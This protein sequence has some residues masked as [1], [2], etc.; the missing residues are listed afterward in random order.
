MISCIAGWRANQSAEG[1]CKDQGDHST[2]DWCENMNIAFAFSLNISE[3]S[4]KHIFF[5]ATRR[6]QPAA[7]DA[8]KRAG[9]AQWHPQ[10]G[11][12]SEHIHSYSSDA[13]IILEI[14][15]DANIFSAAAMHELRSNGPPVVAVSGQ[16]KRHQQHSLHK[17]CFKVFKVQIFWFF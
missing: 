14:F 16:A 6:V 12:H 9:N 15:S 1:C 2:R 8:A 7:P 5:A 17:V 3:T 4:A 11:R 13:Y 10:R